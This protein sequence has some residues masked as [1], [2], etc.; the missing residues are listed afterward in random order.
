MSTYNGQKYLK[1]QL[2]SILSQEG[3]ET[4]LLVRDDGSIDETSAILDEYAR[5]YTNVEIIKGKNIGFA[6]SFMTLVYSGSEYENIDY[7]AFSD[8]DDVWMKDKLISA[9]NM[10]EKVK[11]ENGIVLYFSSARAV[12]SDLNYIFD[13][14]KYEK[15]EYSKASSLVRCYML[16]C[17]M[18][19]SK[20]TARF[21]TSHKPVREIEMHDLWINQTCAFFGKIVYD[22]IPHILYRQ[23]GNNAAG[24][25]KALKVRIQRQIKSFRK[26]SRRHFRELN[27]RC[28]YDTYKNIL[29]EEDKDIVSTVAFYRQ[30]LKSRWKFFSS[31]THVMGV[32][33]SDI[34]LKIRI[35]LGFA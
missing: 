13:F 11:T 23:H 28:F 18:V 9:T 22:R 26:Y 30:S 34:V 27:A 24:V 2:D 12:D 17:T 25:S 7:Y 33:S 8:Q 19:F 6:Q 15:Y 3:V 10:A 32:R 4:Y 35:L 16:G 20:E 31:H 29:S 21:L 5:Q 1:E 14:A